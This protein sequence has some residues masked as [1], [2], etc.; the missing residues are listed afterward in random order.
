MLYSI[1]VTLRGSSFNIGITWPRN[2]I[3]IECVCMCLDSLDTWAKDLQV[4][5]NTKKC[6]V[7]RMTRKNDKTE[8]LYYL[9]NTL[10]V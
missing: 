7:M 3:R 5:F 9:S 2:L 1:C 8:H 10:L 4:K 6:E